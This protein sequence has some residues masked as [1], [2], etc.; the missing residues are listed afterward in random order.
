MMGPDYYT[1]TAA[2]HRDT[3]TQYCT[4][5]CKQCQSA[6]AS[7]FCILYAQYLPRNITFFQGSVKT[8]RV[9]HNIT[10]TNL[11]SWMEYYD[12]LFYDEMSVVVVVSPDHENTFHLTS[13][14]AM[15]GFSIFRE[16]KKEESLCCLLFGILPSTS[17]SNKVPFSFHVI[18]FAGGVV[19]R[20]HSQRIAEYV[21]K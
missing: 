3:H 9:W 13:T 1:A 15:F 20:L 18:F 21:I 11:N 5:D 16:R 19:E 6:G 2:T 10:H 17:A 8:E 7:Q 4:R 14:V 12:E